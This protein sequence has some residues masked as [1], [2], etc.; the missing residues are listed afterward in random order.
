MPRITLFK[1]GHSPPHVTMPQ[2]S[3]V[4]SKNKLVA[5]TRELER[6]RVLEIVVV[7]EHLRQAVAQQDAIGFADVVNR[8]LREPILRAATGGCTHPK[9]RSRDPP[10][11]HGSIAP[12]P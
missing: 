6:G 5:R 10:R 9:C 2:R 1:P 11:R 8:R 3:R 7:L 4:G 12:E